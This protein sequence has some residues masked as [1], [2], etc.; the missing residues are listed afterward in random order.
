MSKLQRKKKK[1][2]VNLIALLV[3]IVAVGSAGVV[4]A[5]DKAVAYAKD[6]TMQEIIKSNLPDNVSD[7]Q[8]QKVATQVQ[9]VMSEEDKETV[10]KMIESKMT[11]SNVTK[12][13][14]YATSGDL[15]GLKSYAQSILSEEEQQELVDMYRSYG[16]EMLEI[17]QQNGIDIS[18][19]Q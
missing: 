17:L 14:D 12:A 10:D 5:K 13:I 16:D 3:I 6:Y 2:I 19:Y 7:E 9:D 1:G 8:V 18:D 4:F 15:S 11:T